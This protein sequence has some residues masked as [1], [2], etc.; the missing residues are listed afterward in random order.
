MG[1]L[2]PGLSAAC[3]GADASTF[4]VNGSPTNQDQRDRTRAHEQRHADDYQVIL[5]DI[6]VPWDKAVTEVRA[7]RKQLSMPTKTNAA[8]SS[9]AMLWGRTKGL[10]TSSRR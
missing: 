3:S 1:N 9:M 4:T 8:P 6:I 7:K 2:L 10:R 5:N